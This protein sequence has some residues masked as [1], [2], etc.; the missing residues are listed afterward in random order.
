[1]RDRICQ[2]GSESEDESLITRFVLIL[3]LFYMENQGLR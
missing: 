3:V 1:M 2:T